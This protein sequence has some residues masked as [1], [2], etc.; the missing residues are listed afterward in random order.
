MFAIKRLHLLV[1]VMFLIILSYSFLVCFFKI[2]RKNYVSIFSH[3]L[4]TTLQRC[5]QYNQNVYTNTEAAPVDKWTISYTSH[6]I[7]YVVAAWTFQATPS[8][9]VCS[10]TDYLFLL[11]DVS[12]PNSLWRASIPNLLCGLDSLYF[13]SSLRS[14]LKSE[15]ETF[16][17]AL[18]CTVEC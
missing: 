17:I 2:F 12:I 8:M 3:S 6:F 9:F 10:S 5:K 16:T 18:E 15:K 4:H 13:T 14:F 7:P 11:W 1:E